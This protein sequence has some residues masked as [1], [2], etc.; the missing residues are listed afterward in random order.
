M[1]K[2]PAPWRV[3]Q[4]ELLPRG[5]TPH[6]GGLG[7]AER[8]R[9][10]LAVLNIEDRW[11]L[12]SA[13]EEMTRPMTAREIDEALMITGLARNDRKR[14]TLALK[15]YPVLIIGEANGR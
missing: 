1:V 13:L 4:G 3:E 5:S 11:L 14:L 9:S 7:R 10:A 6:R 12:L 15:N 8:L 2:S